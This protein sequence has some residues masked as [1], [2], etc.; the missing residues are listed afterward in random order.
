LVVAGEVV[1]DPG[2]DLVSPG[3]VQVEVV[4]VGAGRPELPTEHMA[5]VAVVQVM[6]MV[7]AV[8][9]ILVAEVAEAEAVKVV[10]AMAAA[11][12][13]ARVVQ[14][15]Q[16]PMTRSGAVILVAEAVGAVPL[17]RAVLEI[18][19]GAMVLLVL[20]PA[21]RVVVVL[22]VLAVAVAEQVAVAVRQVGVDQADLAA[23][24]LLA[25]QPDSHCMLQMA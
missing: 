3:P 17:A 13:A 12:P 4:E 20:G 9:V 22:A 25:C 19:V 15:A 5:V 23:C 11:L 2:Q 7:V 14:V 1:A 8:A 24:I 10:E 16:E 18:M 6:V 21:E